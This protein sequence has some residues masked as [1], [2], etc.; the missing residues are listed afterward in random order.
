MPNKYRIVLL[1]KRN[2]E[3]SIASH[4]QSLT[5]VININH[6]VKTFEEDLIKPQNKDSLSENILLKNSVL[7]VVKKYFSMLTSGSSYNNNSEKY[8]KIMNMAL[9]SEG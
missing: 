9:T 4:Y 3:K 1:G 5:S 7:S 2:A 6:I 8:T